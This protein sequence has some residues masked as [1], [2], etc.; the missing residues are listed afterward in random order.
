M[1][2]I[3]LILCFFLIT[4][5]GTS[6]SECSKSCKISDA[7]APVLTQYITDLQT[8]RENI[9]DA[10]LAASID[11][12][13]TAPKI[14]SIASAFNPILN[15]WDYIWSFKY[16]I[17]TPLLN[18][19]PS[20]IRRDH[21]LILREN[22]KLTQILQTSM[23]RLRSEVSVWEICAGIQNCNLN[24]TTA[25]T[26]LTELLKNNNQILQFYR[27]L[28]TGDEILLQNSQYLLTESAFLSE[29][30]NY[31]NASTLNACSQCA[32]EFWK[33]ASE[34]IKNISQKF[35]S[36]GFEM[37][38]IKNTWDTMWA[39]ESA[40]WY[41]K[42]EK[43]LLEGYL[44]EQWVSVNQAEIMLWNLERAN[45]G[46]GLSTS[47]PLTNTPKGLG[48]S[49][50]RNGVRFQNSIL[51]WYDELF[52]KRETIPYI[53]LSRINTEMQ[54]SQRIAAS[55]ATV[56]ENEL[57]YVVVQDTNTQALQ[58]RIIQMHFS[59]V[60]TAN[61]LYKKTDIAE[62]ICNKQW[63]LLGRC[64]FDLFLR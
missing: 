29:M 25:Q 35:E 46:G 9:T 36:A 63:R 28:I 43:E 42:R 30:R 21:E 55:I 44:K 33:N 34:Q 27:A 2:K 52:W 31:Y 13:T 61:L 8:V 19:V 10:L 20:H 50:S 49:L 12:N 47:N 56:Y 53:E 58:A 37:W 64:Q 45:A 38:E 24:N 15:F 57:P 16:Y 18:S 26:A 5:S 23:T 11:Q 39:G 32:W 4:L 3:L 54:D 40:P 14:S 17:K 22:K 51:K 59:L 48:D 6:A 1:K 60:R 41:G 7:P 62:D